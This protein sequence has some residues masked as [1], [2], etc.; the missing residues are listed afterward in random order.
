MT[1]KS[2]ADFIRDKR[3]DKGYSLQKVATQSGYNPATDKFNITG[4]YVNQLENGKIEAESLSIEKL[5]MLAKGLHVSV[6]ELF[7]AALGKDLESEPFE[8]K[9]RSLLTGITGSKQTELLYF[10]ET[11]ILGMNSRNP[12]VTKTGLPLNPGEFTTL[13]GLLD[14]LGIKPEQL[15][16]FRDTV[17]ESELLIEK[18]DAEKFE[19]NKNKKIA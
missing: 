18:Q 2:F 10:L 8:E 19:E 17:H 11:F 5:K 12:R 9:V 13:E 4:S 14:H 16:M 15:K 1:V 6:E 7:F 3:R